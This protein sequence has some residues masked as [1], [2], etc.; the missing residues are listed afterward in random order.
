MGGTNLQRQVHEYGEFSAMDQRFH[1]A[2]IGMA[3]SPGLLDSW[4]AVN[5]HVQASRFFRASGLVDVRASVTEHAAILGALVA[6]DTEAAFAAVRTHVDAG[7]RRSIRGL[8]APAPPSAA[9]PE[10]LKN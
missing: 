3:G 6:Q 2:L 8:A 9:R 4:R 5:I 1:G 7:L 10:R